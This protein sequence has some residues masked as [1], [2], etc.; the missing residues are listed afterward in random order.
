MVSK[1]EKNQ[2]WKEECMNALEAV[3]RNQFRQNMRLIENYE[4]VKGKFIPN[5]YIDDE[6]YQDMIGQL[7]K[8][9]N[10]PSYLRHYDIISQVVNTL[11][12]EWQS[13]PDVFSVRQ[14]GEDAD[15]QFI[16]KQT[17]LLQK[18]VMSQINAEVAQKL[19]DMGLDENKEDF[20]SE[21]EAQQYKQVIEQAKQQLTPPQIQQYMRTDWK[22]AAEIW[23]A[24]QLEWDK[25]RFRQKE[26]EKK[27]FED[28]LIAD[29]CFRH[30]YLTPTGYNQETWNPINVFFQK[31]PDIDYIEDGDYVGR[32][33]W[34]TLPAIIDR[35][36]HKM[37]KSEIEAL[38]ES[39]KKK[40]KRWNYSAGSEYVFENYMVPFKDYPTYDIL[41]QTQNPLVPT[42]EIP[43]LDSSFFSSLYSGKY[44]NESRGF[45][46]VIEGYWKSQ[47]K[48]GIVSYIDPDTNE[49]VK[50]YIDEDIN[51]PSDFRQLDSSID[52][53]EELKT[54]NTVIWTW[55]N[56]VWKGTKIC[57]K[58]HGGF[59]HDLYIDVQPNEFQFKGDF[60]PYGS[61]LP[62][63]GQIFSPRN[64]QSMS[65]VDLMKP[66]QIGF[67]V[68]VNQAYQEMQKDVGKFI[69]M[70]VNMFADVKD[71]GGSQAYEK[72][73]MVAKELGV[74]MV[75]TKP[76]NT[77]GAT[78]PAGGH[79]PKEIDLDASARILSR[80]QIAM[81]FEAMM[82]KQVGFNEY[83]LGQQGSSSTL[84]GIQEGQQRSFAQTES[85]F[86]NFSNYLRRVHEMDLNIAQY[87]QSQNKDVT[88]S[89]V[90]SDMSRAFI[91]LSGSDLLLADIGVFVSNSQEELRQL[92]AMRQLAMSNNTMG[93]SFF[94]LAQVI[95]A[96]SPGEIMLKL[97]AADE[98]RQSQINRQL[99]IE[100]ETAQKEQE[101]KQLELEQKA[102]QFEEEWGEGGTRERIA[103]M[104]T[105]NRQDDNLAD[106][107]GSGIP[108][109][110]EFGKLAQKADADAQK[111]EAQREKNQIDRE[112]M[113]AQRDMEL[114]KLE[115]EKQKIA[116]QGDIEAQKVQIAKIMK[117]QQAKNKAKKKSK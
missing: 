11:S 114:K 25:Q 109:V 37:K 91:K 89:Y 26:K 28:M 48:I 107:D 112:Q 95:T 113:I 17:E 39:Q 68:A 97:K 57:T 24:H 92:E 43:F 56:E 70:D 35:Y 94:D 8:E 79:Y 81:H 83:R 52:D 2:K 18:Y 111:A 101:L 60:N 38:Q 116:M 64:S 27:E 53:E 19:M 90:K 63:C 74:T 29:R 6:G 96:N 3:G 31:S 66:H 30:F 42:N 104:S 88:V 49:L 33:F 4:M 54:P 55:I 102:E 23:G 110:L 86:T 59:D 108:D 78:G 41:R 16:R 73:M 61:K 72:F 1:K 76:S 58:N 44:F 106:A 21:E 7:Q 82:L 36:G 103:Y 50:E 105:F 47:K 46:L 71:W 10:L 34:L 67:N 62:V 80:L 77:Q 117:G 20:Q 65:T 87:V 98:L 22:T 13:R 115:V 75:D 45:Y 32:V 15:N 5:H 51:I 84:G 100:Q 99:E 85:L 14:H 40:D 12:G 93:A 69:V 9:F